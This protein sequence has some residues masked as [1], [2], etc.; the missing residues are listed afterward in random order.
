MNQKIMLMMGAI[1]CLWLSPK[2]H[3]QNQLGLQLGGQHLSFLDQQAT[4]LV[5]RGLGP[6]IRLHYNRQNEAHQWDYSLR[7]GLVAFAPQEP[8]I[9]AQR[10]TSLGGTS[11]GLQA[12]YYYR[13]AERGDWAFSA[14]AGIRQEMMLDFG[15]IGGFPWILGQ[16]NVVLKAKA[17]YQLGTQHHFSGELGIPAFSWIT[18]MPYNQIPRLEDRAPDVVTV[19]TVGTRAPS[20]GSYQRVDLGLSYRYDWNDKWSFSSRYDWAWYHD[21]T[22]KDL[23]AYQGVLTLGVARSW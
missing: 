6:Q 9:R 8:T 20:W 3:A 11:V 14:G 23:W 1:F 16:G 15:D 4:P 7:G 17:D 19:F 22:P 5:Y 10:E 13:F 12:T 21:D 2:L 18:D